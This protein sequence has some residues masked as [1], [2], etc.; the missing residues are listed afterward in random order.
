MV[1]GQL[2]VVSWEVHVEF[3][4]IDWQLT[5]DNGRTAPRKKVCSR[6]RTAEPELWR[7]RL[8]DG[9]RLTY[10]PEARAKD[11]AHSFACASGL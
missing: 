5:T 3:G 8:H 9:S 10:K 11:L 4:G 1:S 6:P 2:A 7:V